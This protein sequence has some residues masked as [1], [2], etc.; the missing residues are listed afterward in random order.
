MYTEYN[1]QNMNQGYNPNNDLYNSDDNGQDTK[2]NKVF[3][4]LW[5]ILLVILLIILLFLGLIQFGVI[6]LASDVAPDE[7]VLNVNEIGI[8][9]GRGY[10]LVTTVL[11]ENANNKQ[12]EYVSSD[13]KI[14][15]VNSVSGYVKGLKE[16]TATIT[17]K[18]LINEIQ[19]E[20]LVTVEGNGVTVQSINLNS[21]NID[22]AVGHTYGLTYRI[23]PSNATELGA[24]FY[25]SDPSVATVD[26]KGVVR[27]VREGTAIITIS[28]NNGNLT[29]TANVTVYKKGTTTTTQTGEVVQTVNYPSSIK[30]SSN[31]LS[32]DV[33]STG[34]LKATITPSNAISTLTWSSS[35]PKVATVDGNGLVRAIGAGSANIVAKTIDNKTASCKITVVKK[36]GSSSAKVTRINITTKYIKMVVGGKPFQMF[37]EIFPST[38][39][40]RTIS[41]SSSNPKVASVD[42]SGTVRALSDG[43][44]VIT[45]RSVDGG[46]T[47]TV[48]VDVSGGSSGIEAKSIAFTKSS[49]TVSLGNTQSLPSHVTYNPSNTTYKSL[50]F[51]S[52]NPN[53]ATVDVDGKVLGV[54]VG[55]A[56]ITATTKQGTASAKTTIVVKEIPATGVSILGQTEATIKVGGNFTIQT[57]VKPIDAS[58]KTVTFISSNPNVATVE[59]DGTVRGVGQGTATIDIKANGGAASSTF[60]VKVE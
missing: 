47:S 30:L 31:S 23:T 25:S 27:G 6:S 26:S 17:V 44:V 42:S 50:S 4:F 28:T 33:G 3:G 59:K 60:T 54:G 41:W 43:S 9:K 13:P 20:C 5:K 29:D 46:H 56:I 53:V 45:A 24:V 49:F 14:A 10:Q 40:N 55:Q 51:T 48:T 19:S 2:T 57:Q 18:T 39:T 15:S 22:L 52:S 16:G 11:P 8:K 37:A 58:N 12:V 1:S 38:A 21:K 32:L 34:Q 7:V 35:N 36:S